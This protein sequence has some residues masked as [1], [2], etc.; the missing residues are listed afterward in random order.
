MKAKITQIVDCYN[1]LGESKVTKLEES[2]VIKIVKARKAMRSIA[3][4][5]EAFSKDI[6]EKLKYEGF[7][8]DDKIRLE[9]VRKFKENHS[10]QLTQEEEESMKRISDYFS[11]VLKAKDE[12]GKREIEIEIEPF[13]LKEE[14]SI[15]ILSENGYELKKLDKIDLIF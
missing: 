8:E 4:E 6:D 11:K 7:D 13:K 14:T 3:E 15:K 5:Y 1:I 10:Y 9:I 2:E 12:E